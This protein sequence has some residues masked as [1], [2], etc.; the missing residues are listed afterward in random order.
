MTRSKFVYPNSPFLPVFPHS[1]IIKKAQAELESG[2][3]P[4]PALAK[5]ILMLMRQWTQIHS[6]NPAF[7]ESRGLTKNNLA[8][9]A[10]GYAYPLSTIILSSVCGQHPEEDRK[11]VFEEN[12]ITTHDFR[13]LTVQNQILEDLRATI[14]ILNMDPSAMYI[15]EF[16]K[17]YPCFRD[18]YFLGGIEIASVVFYGIAQELVRITGNDSWLVGFNPYQTE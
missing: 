2:A 15:F 4:A 16:L 10:Q 8:M 18:E 5:S 3:D 14:N 7:L 6:A 13:I 1:E 17:K 12:I 9:L 11:R